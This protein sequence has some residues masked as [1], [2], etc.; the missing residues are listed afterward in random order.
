MKCLNCP[1][2]LT[3]MQTKFCSKEC[4]NMF[5]TNKK[6][7]CRCG[8]KKCVRSKRCFECMCNNKVERSLRIEARRVKAVITL[9]K[10]ITKTKGLYSSY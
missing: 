4:S 2:K 9:P 5:H 6:D 1:K 3:G 7:F 8:N 10:I